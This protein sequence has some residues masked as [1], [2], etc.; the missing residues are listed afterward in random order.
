MADIGLVASIIAVIQITTAV[1]TQ[2]Y[3]YG[4]CVKNA[5]NDIKEINDGLKDVENVLTKLKDLADRAKKS[6]EPLDKWPTLV[7]LNSANGPLLQCKLAMISLCT[8]LAPVDGFAKYTERA[9]WP[10]KKKKVE[11]CLDD[12]VKQKKIFIESLNVEHM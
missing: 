3:K 9:L 2:A 12:I 7:S 5:T 4:H 11:K 1:T 6:G 10:R 8:E